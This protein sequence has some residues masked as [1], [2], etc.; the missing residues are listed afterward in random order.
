M[1]NEAV[2]DHQDW[3]DTPQTVR[4]LTFENAVKGNPEEKKK[5]KEEGIPHS[6]QGVCKLR[7]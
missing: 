3:S 4:S 6:S 2:L 5:K 7:K 1:C